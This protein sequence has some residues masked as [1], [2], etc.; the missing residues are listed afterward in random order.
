MNQTQ[1]H[2]HG[3]KL[4]ALLLALVMMVSLLP[5][6]AFATE[7]GAEL[8]PA[9]TQP[10]EAVQ[11]PA[12]PTE[13]PAAAPADEPAAPADK[14]AEAPTEEPAPVEDEE[15][16]AAAMP[17]ALSDDVAVAAETG[18]W[19]V[20]K[21]KSVSLPEGTFYRTFLLDC[22]RKYFTV[23]QIKEVIDCLAENHYTHIQLA[24]GNDA[25][26]FLLND[27]SITVNGTNYTSEQVTSAITG[28]NDTFDTVAS[29]SPGT[30]EEWTEADMDSIITYANEKGIG[31]IP[32]FNAPGHMYTVV[33]AME[34]LGLGPN[35]TNIG[36]ASGVSPNWA[37]YPTNAT[38]VN[39]VQALVQKYVNYFEGKGCQFFNIGADESGITEATYPKYAELVN[40][41]AAMVQ[42]AGMVAWAFNDGIYHY[43]NDSVTFDSDIAIC[44]WTAGWSGYT[45][46]VAAMQV[47]KGHKII[48]TNDSWY[49]VLGRNTNDWA[50]YTAAINN[51]NT[52]KCNQVPGGSTTENGCTLAVWCDN[53]N[54]DYD[55]TRIKTL[56]STLASKNPTYFVAATT[57]GGDP[58]DSSTGSETQLVE[59]TI[60]LT[61][62]GTTTDTIEGSY[63][64]NHATDP[65]GIATAVG[66]EP[67][68]EE[69]T[70]ASTTKISMNEDGTYKGAIGD[71]TNW[72]TLDSDGTIGS[73]TVAG[74]ATEFTVVRSTTAGWWSVT[75]YT[76]YANGRYLTATQNGNS[77]SISSGT[78]SENWHYDTSY[79]G[80]YYGET[81]ARYLTYSDGKWTVASR[82]NVNNY[83]RLYKVE[84][85]KT[86]GTKTDVT[87]NGVS[88]GT[89]YVTIGNVHY[90]INVTDQAPD[91]AMTSDSI[92]LEYWITNIKVY[93][94]N[95]QSSATSKTVSKND[96]STEDGIAIADIAPNPAYS[97]FD[98][99]VTLTYWQAMR[100][101]ADNK[102]T[103]DADDDETAD[104]TTLTHVRYHG[105]AWQYKTA[106]GIWH[107]FLSTDQLVAYYLQQIEVTEEVDTYFK[108]WGY[109]TES[110]TPNTSSGKGQVAL[111]V[112]VVYPDGTVSPSEED[113]YSKTVIYNYSKTNRDIGIV[114]PANNSDYTISKITVT[115]GQRNSNTSANVWYTTDTITW[116]KKTNAAGTEWYDE[117]EYWNKDSGTTPMVNGLASNIT[118]SG[119]NNAKLV[120]IYLEAVAKETNL[121]VVYYDDNASA[122]IATSQVVVTEGTTFTNALKNKAGAVI[123]TKRDW[124]SNVV[125]NANYLPDDAYVTN[126]SNVNQTFN[127][128]I[129]TVPCVADNYKSGIYEYISADISEDG[130]TLTLH[131]NIKEMAVAKRYVVDFGLPVVIKDVLANHTNVTD[132]DTVSYFG[133]S[134]AGGYEN[135]TEGNYG[136]VTVRKQSNSDY[137][138]TYALTKIANSEITIPVYY[139]VGSD[140]LYETSI[141][142]IPA[143]NV[144]YEDSFA[145]FTN[146]KGAAAGAT[147][148]ADGAATTAT[149]A[150]EE[151]GEK[152]NVYGYDNAYDS[153]TTF[154]MGSARKVTVTKAM[155]DG[156]NN[157]T[158]AWPTATFTFK[159]TGFDVISLTDNNSG[160]ITYEVKDSA[161]ETVVS[162]FVDNYYGY[163][164][165]NSQF[166]QTDTDENALYQL[167]VIKVANL[168]YGTYTVTI[169]AAYGEFFDKTG[170]NQY[171]FW[172]DAI[173][174][175]D[176]MGK[177]YDYTSDGEDY[178]QYFEL[179]NALAATESGYRA[180]LIEGKEKATQ[181]EYKNFGPNHEVYLAK[182]QTLA[183]KL[184]D[185]LG[186]IAS[187]QLGLKSV[188]GA[189]TYK[190][191]TGEG[192]TVT[193]ATDMYYDIT[194][195]AKNGETVLITNTG[196][197]IL[198]LTNVKVTF[199]AA[200][201]S[202]ELA[203][204][205]ED[206]VNQAVRMVRA[207]YAAPV[208][209][210]VFAPERFEA[211]WNRDTVRAGQKATLTVK[212][213]EDVAYIQ[214]D[215]QI[216]DT[217]RTRTQR[218]GWGAN[219]TTVTY[220]QFT[221]T[222]TAAETADYTVTAFN[223]DDVA[224][225]SIT[226]TLTVQAASQGSGFVGWLESIFGRW[227]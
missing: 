64:G 169:T 83:A 35:G 104:G 41:Y 29:Y 70:P 207:M 125:G 161:G 21:E 12:A 209:P 102:Q 164:Y 26:R 144:Y 58:G 106:D 60:S 139:K 149:Q 156:W 3:K 90:T 187:V 175:Y 68:T 202:V 25:L 16:L 179:R 40:S 38:A 42:N 204:M 76:I 152:T 82:S 51:M 170:D 212:T 194:D 143:S 193:T 100:L 31:V 190:I 2:T 59:K 43:N 147:W 46:A 57:E 80:F 74:E 166:T 205:G 33:K 222:I 198:S 176:P 226:T 45:P 65:A 177:T 218:T 98:G 195:A 153:C 206:T 172:L 101:D 91:N 99:T 163:K 201:K 27:M 20:T 17:A 174:V 191:G 13:A 182:D 69:D 189:A 88:V 49:Y 127:K 1:K 36:T 138:I 134:V 215:G 203:L 103:E 181:T 86:G 136:T 128:N 199:T 120:L 129:S 180:V 108:D 5:M 171:S 24:F 150:L 89:T 117:T 167:P 183:F 133:V 159:G 22:G 56:I 73:T 79:D 173:R 53:P 66:C 4:L 72:L 116:D 223:A 93:E 113:M 119:K 158:S 197:N 145:S 95:S 94:T 225:E 118:W 227:F 47:A 217:Y 114:A 142:I 111:T 115:N 78:N 32:L 135:P 178:P 214:V 109:R 92:T 61:V 123:G 211:S 81:S 52:V 132:F 184:T 137:T 162:K 84:P 7:P 28:G 208:E 71:G 112:A 34:T 63:A 54:A 67:Y 87:F 44:Y 168:G 154:S 15:P 30:K 105:N 151:L 14:T 75:N 224:S 188:D 97:F 19:Y 160:L 185:D 10:A 121:N 186:S 96:A 165:E 131:Y 50:G 6:S 141:R 216:I 126:T 110:Q 23:E 122:Q 107:Y 219:A 192:Q 210:E 8:A 196:S 37:I 140:T 220:R 9:V 85:A 130:K 11:E 157:D 39:F 18:F 146:G 200:E 221:Y 148:S 62:G 48:S 155:A 77:Y 55:N 213:S 124:N